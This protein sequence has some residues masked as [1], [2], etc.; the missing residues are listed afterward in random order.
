M[1]E[2]SG[3]LEPLESFDGGNMDWKKYD[4]VVAQ[5]PPY[6][7]K[8]AIDGLLKAEIAKS[9]LR[10]LI[11]DDD[12]TGVQTVQDVSVY[13]DWSYDSLMA[14]MREKEKLFFVLTNS[15][16]MGE[17]ESRDVHA[18]IAR[19]ATDVSAATGCSF[20]IISRGDS[21]LRGHYPMETEILAKTL[22]QRGGEKIDG[23]IICPSFFE[24]GRFTIGNVHYVRRGDDLVPVSD[25]EFARDPTFCYQSS[26]LPD[27]VEERT[28]GIYRAKDVLCIPLELLRSGSL[29]KVE[30][31]LLDVHDFGKVCVNALEY[32]DLKVFCIALYRAM[33][34]GKRFMFRTAA[35]FVSA[36]TGYMPQPLLTH[37]DLSVPESRHGGVIIVGSH[38]QKTSEQ[39]SL[40]LDSP[41]IV[42]VS[43]DSDKVLEGPYA[44]SSEIQRCIHAEERILKE[45]K[46]AVCYTSRTLLSLPEDTKETALQRSVEI[47]KGVLQLVKG[48]SLAPSFIIAKGGITSS[49]IGVKALGVRRAR[50]AGQIYPG[51]PVWSLGPEC[52]FPSIP[53]VI[54][55]GNVGERETLRDCYL[56]LGG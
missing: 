30:A 34:K 12:P 43:F 23:E 53:Y 42:P 47:S 17:D 8:A 15:R 27:Y 38:T 35:S 33:G 55:P 40:L 50:V 28:H 41:G 45:G 20:A 52:K 9:G 4:E 25:T 21:T 56:K 18:S 7:D 10:F 14:G 2:T 29:D 6:T 3:T 5:Y 51:I 26:S 22:M 19:T 24:G 16:S 49:D 48:L 32:A 31:L 46:T 1:Q 36:I 39:L 37:E 54:F 44:F 11:L 13:T